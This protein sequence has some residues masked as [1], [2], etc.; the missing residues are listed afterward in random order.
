MDHINKS[1]VGIK[2]IYKD[3]L[4]RYCEILK[5]ITYAC[6]VWGIVGLMRYFAPF[7]RGGL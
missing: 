1:K 4:L 2:Y 6:T 5:V 7:F 3:K